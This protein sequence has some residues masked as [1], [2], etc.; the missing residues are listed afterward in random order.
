MNVT[1]SI[2][3]MEKV[4]ANL[5]VLWELCDTRYF[6]QTRAEARLLAEL[7]SARPSTEAWCRA[8]NRLGMQLVNGI[9]ECDGEKLLNSAVVLGYDDCVLPQESIYGLPPSNLGFADAPLGRIGEHCTSLP[10]SKV[11]LGAL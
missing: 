8:A 5:M 3:F 10:A 1:R 9:V 7:I 11:P 4:A 2:T 6:C